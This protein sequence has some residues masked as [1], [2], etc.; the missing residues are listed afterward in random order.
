[1][2]IPTLSNEIGAY[3][4]PFLPYLLK[5]GEKAAEEAGKKFGAAAWEKAQAIWAKLRGKDEVLKASKDAQAMPGDED[6]Q[7]ALRL[8]LKKLLQADEALRAE[9]AELWQETKR[10]VGGDQIQMIVNISGQM[11]G[12]IIGKRV[13]G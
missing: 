6:A 3:L 13:G 8:Q 2:D 10:T 9:L 4:L 7:A 11:R 12:D 5:A 1:M